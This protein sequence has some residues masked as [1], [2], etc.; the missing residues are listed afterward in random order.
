MTTVAQPA[1]IY[2][3]H[4]VCG[5]E[6]T[7]IRYIGLTTQRLTTRLTNHRS[8]SRYGIKT[9][10]YHWMRKHGESNIR[11]RE[12]EVTDS[13][14]MDARE[15]DWIERTPELLNISP[16]GEGG[17]FRGK[18]RPDISERMTGENHPGSLLT[19]EAVRSIRSRYT[20][21]YGELTKFAKEFGV[22]V[23]SIYGVVNYVTWKHVTG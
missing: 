8:M 2:G 20:G 19:E 5:C 18:K 1:F 16:G 10:V 4:C 13:E 11:I 12:L 22:S 7:Q 3:L 21:R 23:N 14:S 17:A 15:I 6:D 9:P